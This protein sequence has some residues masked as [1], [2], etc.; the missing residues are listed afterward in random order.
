MKQVNVLLSS[1]LLGV[2]F[3]TSCKKSNTEEHL[4]TSEISVNREMLAELT[5]PPHAP[6]AVGRR[7][8]KKLIVNMEI[9]EKVGTMT[10][11]T[12]YNY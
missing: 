11:G 2:L 1:V 8:A 5:A 7:K 4:V 3:F 9:L 12:T 10:D 6:T